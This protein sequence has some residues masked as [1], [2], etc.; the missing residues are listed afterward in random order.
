MINPAENPVVVAISPLMLADRLRHARESCGL[1]QDAAAHAIGVSQ[2]ALV[3]IEQG[4]RSVSSLELAKLAFLFGRDMRDFFREEFPAQDATVSVPGAETDAAEHGTAQQRRRERIA[5][6]RELTNLEQ[7]LEIAESHGARDESRR[8]FIGLALEAYRRGLVTGGKL[9]QLGS[10]AGLDRDAIDQL[11][12]S[13][14]LYHHA[15]D[16]APPALLPRR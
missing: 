13:V 3:E 15:N 6:G 11:V 1:S 14:G 4:S 2:S 7:L 8:R 12:A 16:D 10:M 5:F 9:R